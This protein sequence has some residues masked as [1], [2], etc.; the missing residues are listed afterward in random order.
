M[1]N[2][3][4]QAFQEIAVIVSLSKFCKDHS[5]PKSSVH[6][7]CKELNI[8][9]SEGLDDAAQQILANE[10][11]LVSEASMQ[12][13]V[14]PRIE[15]EQGNHRA[16]I[17]LHTP[18]QFSLEKFRTERTRQAIA[19]PAEFMAGIDA[20]V[21]GLTAAMEQAELAQESELAQ[22]RRIKAAA[23]RRLGDL[24]AR[25]QEHRLTTDFVALMQNNELE[26][27]GTVADEI[28]DM[29][30]SQDPLDS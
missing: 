2:Q 1:F 16:S 30:K 26:E 28:Q 21:E 22:T 29:G 27:V 9:T 11:N 13:V 17:E 12:D 24:K 19:N 14:V 4:Y 10:F 7:R 23:N 18:E 20:V 15:V 25:A 8:D 6:A 3:F 5:I